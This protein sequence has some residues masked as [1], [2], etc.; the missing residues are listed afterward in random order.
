MTPAGTVFDESDDDP[1]Y[2]AVLNQPF[3]IQLDAPTMRDLHA[4][5]Q[6]VPFDFP[7]PMTG[8]V[9]HGSLRRLTDASFG[10]MRVLGIAFTA[11][12]PLHGT[13]P[14][15]PNLQLSGSIAMTGTA[16]YAYANALLLALDATLVIDGKLAGVAADEGVTIVYQR[17][18]RPATQAKRGR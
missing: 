5:S 10:G 16:Y 18:I 9:L 11:R 13:L 14:D 4:V 7:S 17:R 2:L 8:A 1:D 6:A 12:G 3:S 15:R